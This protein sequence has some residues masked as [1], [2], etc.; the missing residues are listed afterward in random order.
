MRLGFN[1]HKDKKINT[2]DFFHQV[3]IPVY[4]PNQEGYFKDSFT[5]LQYCLNSLFLTSNSKTY[6]SIID[7]SSCTEVRDYLDKLFQEK[8]IHEIIHTT[9]IGKLNAILK[10]IVGHN[11]TLV[12]ISDADVLFLNN[13]QS[14]TYNVFNAFPK[15]GVVSTTPNSRMVKHYTSSIFIDTLFSKKLHFSKVENPKAMKEFAESI[16]N[17]NF[18]KD[19]HLQKYLTVSSRENCKAVIGAGHFVA[20]YRGD[21][22]NKIKSK[23][24]EYSLGGD[25]E[26]IILDKSAIENDLWRLSTTNNYTYHL[27]NTK[28]DWMEKVFNSI[29]NETNIDFQVPELKSISY[30]KFLLWFKINF[31]GKILFK[32]SIWKLFLQFKG[33]KKID[34]NN[35]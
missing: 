2:N 9:A 4:I 20:T 35:Y 7:N 13:W 16:K 29:Q 25:S 26:E 18:F 30:N 19:I 3:I 11:F 22:F 23:Y 21:I 5:V 8:K 14:E 1:P 34:S 10:G 27:G 28:E 31:L 17:S 32:K 12:T 33:L 6:F 15:A 24:S